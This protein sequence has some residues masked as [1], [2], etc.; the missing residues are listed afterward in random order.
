MSM[1]WQGPKSLF[2]RR[3]ASK[4]SPRIRHD[5]KPSSTE[6]PGTFNVQDRIKVNL[7]PVSTSYKYPS[8]AL[9]TRESLRQYCTPA[10]GGWTASTCRASCKMRPSSDVSREICLRLTF[11]LSLQQYN[12]TW[13]SSSWDDLFHLY[14]FCISWSVFDAGVK[15]QFQLQKIAVWPI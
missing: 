6:V 15:K 5:L 4:K 13:A 1:W 14:F 11:S 12:S 10:A 9:S 2:S 7:A 3:G 8:N